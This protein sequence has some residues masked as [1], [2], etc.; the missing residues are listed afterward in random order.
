MSCTCVTTGHIKDWFQCERCR[1][2]YSPEAPADLEDAITQ[3]CTQLSLEPDRQAQQLIFQRIQVL[4]GMR[5]AEQ[6]KRL[7][8]LRGLRG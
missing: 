7:E 3:A 4:H 5:S 1:L 6:V 2:A 8:E